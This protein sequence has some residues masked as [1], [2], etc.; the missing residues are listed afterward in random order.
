M[1]PD[2]KDKKP[3]AAEAAGDAEAPPLTSLAQLAKAAREQ[4]GPE[5]DYATPAANSTLAAIVRDL[6]G[7]PELL[8]S[9]EHKHRLR[10]GRRGKVGAL[11]LEYRPNIRAL[12]LHY[13]GFPDADPTTVKMHRYTFFQDKGPKGEWHRMDEGGEFIDDV[14]QAISRLYPEVAPT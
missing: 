1:T 14:H 2:D 10:L 9:R 4:L 5:P 13:L 3:P 7:M 6:K 12:E 8:V 11:G